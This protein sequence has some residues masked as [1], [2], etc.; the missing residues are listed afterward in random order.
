MFCSCYPHQIP[1]GTAEVLSGGKRNFHRDPKGILG[2]K[3]PVSQL[4]HFTC[5]MFSIAAGAQGTD[6]I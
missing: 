1:F 4:L 2:L 3:L 6:A 5:F